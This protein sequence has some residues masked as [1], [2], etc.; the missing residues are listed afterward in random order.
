MAIVGETQQLAG[1]ALQAFI[2]AQGPQGG[3]AQ[4]GSGR[5]P[6]LRG[7]GGQFSK[8]RATA[9]A[10]GYPTIETEP[11][12]RL[13]ELVFGSLGIFLA[14]GVEADE[15]RQPGSLA[16]LHYADIVL[17]LQPVFRQPLNHVGHILGPGLVRVCVEEA[18]FIV[19]L[20]A[21]IGQLAWDEGCALGVGVRSFAHHVVRLPTLPAEG[22]RQEYPIAI[23][24]HKLLPLGGDMPIFRCF[25]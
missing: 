14:Q 20:A 10:V 24:R 25:H 15:G 5:A 19:L 1:F 9:A 13:D 21:L 17:P 2:P 11:E 8:I 23:S 7:K 4:N 22:H 12:R 6:P 16:A 3:Q 18:S